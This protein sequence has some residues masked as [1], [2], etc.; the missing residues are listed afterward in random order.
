M[1]ERYIVVKLTYDFGKSLYAV[2]DRAKIYKSERK[3]IAERKRLNEVDDS[4][5]RA[6]AMARQDR[7]EQK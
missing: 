3:A 5:N 1:T 2:V 4:I 7:K 6:F